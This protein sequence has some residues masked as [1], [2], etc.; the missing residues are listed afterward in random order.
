MEDNY[1]AYREEVSNRRGRVPLI[2]FAFPHVRELALQSDTTHPSFN[3]FQYVRFE[4]EGKAAVV[5]DCPIAIEGG[6]EGKTDPGFNCPIATVEGE[7]E[8]RRALD[9]DRPIEGGLEGRTDPDFVSPIA[10]VEA[11][12]GGGAFLDFDRSVA[13]EEGESGGA[14][15][16][17]FGRPIPTIEGGFQGTTSLGIPGMLYKWVVHYALF[18]CYRSRR[19]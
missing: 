17:D 5:L 19:Q 10:T 9:L 6:L 1:G 7:L 13:T 4:M 18:N 16:L 8:G 12:L 14:A 15:F 2:L 3:L 11:E